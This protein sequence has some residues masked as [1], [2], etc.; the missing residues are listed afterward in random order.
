[1]EE[2]I[3]AATKYPTRFVVITGG[4]PLLAPKIEELTRELM[5]TGSHITI[6]TAGTIYKPVVCDLL[7]LSPKLANST[8]WKKASGK[9]ASMHEARRIKLAVLKKFLAGYDCQLKFVVDQPE[10]F[11]EVRELLANLKQDQPQRVLIMAQGKNAQ[12]IRSKAK[13]IVEACKQHGY[14]YA[15]RLHIDLYGNRRG[16]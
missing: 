15:P 9:F 6:E 8:P 13:W 2:I 12:Q 10:D 4:E 16:T 11:D 7:S 3:G 1:M 14:R 5:K